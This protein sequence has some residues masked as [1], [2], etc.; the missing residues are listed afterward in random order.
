MLLKCK[1]PKQGEG[2]YLSKRKNS[3]ILALF[4]VEL[5]WSYGVHTTLHLKS[6]PFAKTEKRFLLK[7]MFWNC[8]KL[9][10]INPIDDKLCSKTTLVTWEAALH[11]SCGN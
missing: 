10:T 5:S 8:A 1:H 9:L 6:E 11:K 2:D 4:Y 7:E 3:T